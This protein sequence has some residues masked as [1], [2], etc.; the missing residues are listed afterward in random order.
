MSKISV[1]PSSPFFI[2]FNVT[3]SIAFYVDKLGFECRWQTPGFAI[4]GRGFAQFMLKSISD[5]VPP[6]PNSHRHEWARWDA[7]IYLD[8]PDSLAAEYEKKE[9]TLFRG[10]TNTPEGL[11]GFE[12]EDPDGYICFFGRPV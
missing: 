3:D 12:T 6:L 11:R 2:V 9:V 10:L 8:D 1:G 5:T 4:V 7:F